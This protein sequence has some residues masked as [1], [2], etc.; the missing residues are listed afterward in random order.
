M[1]ILGFETTDA[2]A[3][4]ALYLNGT[5]YCKELS[6]KLRH[7]ESVLPAAER[8]L[9]EHDLNTPDI[10]KGERVGTFKLGS[11]VVLLFERKEF[12]PVSLTPDHSIKYGE[13]IALF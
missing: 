5:V 11:T 2:I 8:M 3:S 6:E 12:T 7:A 4:V 10:Q 1:I 9:S 13:S